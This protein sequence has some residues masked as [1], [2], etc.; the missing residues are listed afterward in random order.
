MSIN[1][2]MTNFKKQCAM[3]KVNGTMSCEK[4]NLLQTILKTELGFPGFVYP[5]VNGQSTAFG[6]ANAGLDYGS[7]SIWSNGKSSSRIFPKHWQ[8]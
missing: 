4:E 1:V 6:S 3:T 2:K 5:D 8:F 7:S